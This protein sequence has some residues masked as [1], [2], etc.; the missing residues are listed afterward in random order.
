MCQTGLSRESD[1]VLDEANLE[2]RAVGQMS[3][4]SELCSSAD[5]RT[6][7]DVFSCSWV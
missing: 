7:G 4:Q 6:V 5:E 1:C 3:L 2:C